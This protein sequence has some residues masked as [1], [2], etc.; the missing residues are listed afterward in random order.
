MPAKKNMRQRSAGWAKTR[1]E[2]LRDNPVCHWCKKRKATEADHI[3][4]VDRGGT[5]DPDNLVPSC[6]QCNAR[7]GANYK[8]AK[9]RR[10]QAARPGATKQKPKSQRKPKSFLVRDQQITP[11][12]SGR[13]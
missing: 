13:P 4:E 11:R 1:A 2:L 5:N 3:I 9:Q 12:P 6:K 8:A 7:R 10:T